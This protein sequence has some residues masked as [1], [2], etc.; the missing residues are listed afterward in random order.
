[1]ARVRTTPQPLIGTE[2]VDSSSEVPMCLTLLII[3]YLTVF[4]C[5]RLTASCLWRCFASAA[6]RAQLGGGEAE[7]RGSAGGGRR[8]GRLPRAGGRAHGPCA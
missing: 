7:N 5:I 6:E 4:D 8:V 3:L 2:V 1:M